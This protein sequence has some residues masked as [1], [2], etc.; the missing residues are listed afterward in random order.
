MESRMAATKGVGTMSRNW[1]RLAE[2]HC[3]GS[4]EH[5]GCSGHTMRLVYINTSDHVVVEFDPDPQDR[6]GDARHSYVFDEE[7]F[8]RMVDLAIEDRARMAALSYSDQQKSG[9][10][11]E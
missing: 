9:N 2:Y 4:C 1:G 7:A 6:P 5:G 8:S 3:T 11:A 10:K